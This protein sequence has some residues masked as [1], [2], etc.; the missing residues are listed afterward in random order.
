MDERGIKR[1]MFLVV[2]LFMFIG[3]HDALAQTDKNEELCWKGKINH[4]KKTQKT[5]D[6]PILIYE[7]Y[8]YSRKFFLRT[9]EEVGGRAPSLQEAKIL[10]CITR[11]SA[12]KGSCNYNIISTFPDRSFYNTG[13]VKAIPTRKVDTYVLLIDIQ[14]AEVIGETKFLGGK[15]PPCPQSSPPP[16]L[17]GSIASYSEIVQWVQKNWSP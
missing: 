1:C 9:L 4:L 3:R 11:I 10:V 6:G 7:S 16:E 8:E 13:A 5:G 14:N 17:V 12:D 2:L 15:P